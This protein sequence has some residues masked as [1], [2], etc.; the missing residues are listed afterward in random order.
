MR[1]SQRGVGSLQ[2]AS[3]VQATQVPTVESVEV[4]TLPGMQPLP[5]PRQ[6]VVQV[7]LK[8]LQ[9]RPEVLPPQSE[10]W[11]QPQV[12]SVRQAEPTPSALQ[13]LVSVEVHSTQAW[14]VVL[15]ISVSAQSLVSRHSTQ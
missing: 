15:Q 7:E 14:L 4:Q 13:L 2:W 3:L 8:V 1:V 11:V 12:S 5:V 6:P 10:S 9:M